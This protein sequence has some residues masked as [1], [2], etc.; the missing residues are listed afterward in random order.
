MRYHV[1]IHDLHETH[2][3]KLDKLA[4]RYIKKWLNIQ[5]RG[6]TDVGLFHPYLLA[7]KQPSQLYHEGHTSNMMLMRFKGDQTVNTCINSKIKREEKWK[8]K[9]STA[10][11]SDMLVAQIVEDGLQIGTSYTDTCKNIQRG[12]LSIKKTISEEIKKRSP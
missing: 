1:S 8:K 4:K 10:L 6:V 7:M 5:T 2:L 3:N 11:K 9:S 12:K